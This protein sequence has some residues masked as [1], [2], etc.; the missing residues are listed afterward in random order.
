M[1]ITSKVMLRVLVFYLVITMLGTRGQA[2]G[3]KENCDRDKKTIEVFCA[4]CIS[5]RPKARANKKC[6]DYQKIR[7]GLRVSSHNPTRA[8]KNKRR[9]TCGSCK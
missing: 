9:E 2:W 1:M 7:Y 4:N 8:D 3:T 6:C 5:Y